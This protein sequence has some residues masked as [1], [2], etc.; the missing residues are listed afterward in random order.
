[1]TSSDAQWKH[2]GE[3]DPFWGVITQ[4]R[5]RSNNLNPDALDGFYASGTADIARFHARLQAEYGAPD[6]FDHVLDFGCG[7]GRLLC[8]LAPKADQLV[9]ID[10]SAGML[11]HARRALDAR[12]HVN[13]ALC[14]TIA[15]ARSIQHNFD[16]VCSYIVL[17][18]IPPDHGFALI[19]DLLAAIK[20]GGFLTLHINAFQDGTIQ[21]PNWKGRLR[22]RLVGLF[23]PRHAS[24][25][26][27]S[28]Y[29]YDGVALG[30]LLFKYGFSNYRLD[31]ENHGGQHGFVVSG[32]RAN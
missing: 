15:Q 24:Q 16:W 8:G 7:V 4:E 25:P 21:K 20:P 30:K 3:T 32:R 28:M 12:G 19:E 14:N 9:G 29:H 10:V 31:H 18:H 6:R 22:E 23:A 5:F 1:V 13:V 27:L 11:A 2:L 17:Q 26:R